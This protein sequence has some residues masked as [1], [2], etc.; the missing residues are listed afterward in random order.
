MQN[1]CSGILI[2]DELEAFMIGHYFLRGGGGT[3]RWC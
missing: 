1:A 2:M 3:R